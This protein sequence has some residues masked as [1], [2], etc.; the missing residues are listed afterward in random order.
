MRLQLLTAVV[1][2]YLKRPD[3]AQ[4]LVETV[5]R[6]AT[7]NTLTPDI[8]DRAYVYWRLL[9]TNTD[10][11]KEV[12][13]AEKPVI[14][15]ESDN[16]ELPVLNMLLRHISSLASVY[17]KP[18][19]LFLSTPVTFN[20]DD[21]DEYA[22]ELEEDP[23]AAIE[24]ARAAYEESMAGPSSGG[25]GATPGPGPS[26]M[27]GGTVGGGNGAPVA[28]G[29]PGGGSGGGVDLLGGD[30]GGSGSAPPLVDLL[31]GD[32]PSTGAGGSGSGGSGGTIDLLGDLLGGG[33]TATATPTYSTAATVT[34]PK[35]TWLTAE[36]GGG[37]AV[38]GAFARRNGVILME[39][40]IT[41]MSQGPMSD[42]AVLFNKNTFGAAA[43]QMEARALGPG[44]SF[45]AAVPVAV[46]GEMAVMNPLMLLQ[47]ALKNNVDVY[48]FATS[49]PLDVLFVEGAAAPKETFL[50]LWKSIANFEVANLSLAIPTAQLDAYYARLADYNVFVR[51]GLARLGGL[52]G[53]VCFLLCF[54][55]LC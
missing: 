20:D 47:V 28:Y 36:A 37:M 29:V 42:F 15:N 49:L 7:E 8:R 34:V 4:V 16:L 24:A 1:K 12:V 18:P 48:Y 39:M 46:G 2:C 6:V 55:L 23:A 38:T 32:V 21:D 33:S 11:T 51:G 26:S 17:H 50:P 43:G 27:E 53:C 14:S 44:E 3:E 19:E 35:Q 41:N 52:E 40:S 9:S 5:L 22:D 13:V 30:L 31:G 10:A 25:G 45:D 54:F